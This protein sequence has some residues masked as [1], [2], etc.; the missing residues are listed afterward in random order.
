MEKFSDFCNEV[1]LV[2]DKVALSEVL[3]QPI[4]VEKFRKSKSKQ[5]EGT[6][7]VTIQIKYQ[8]KER[9]I[10][11]GSD[12]LKNQ[13]EKYKDHLPFETIIKKINNYYS[14]T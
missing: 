11:T 1:A 10:F 7:Y 5:K 13:L 3:N 6:E 9:V 12:V 4:E 2:G 14:F 8:G